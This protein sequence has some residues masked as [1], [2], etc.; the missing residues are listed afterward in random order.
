MPKKDTTL[1][2]FLNLTICSSNIYS[3]IMVCQ[4]RIEWLKGSFLS[5][6]SSQFV[7]EGYTWETMIQCDDNECSQNC[8]LWDVGEGDST[9]VV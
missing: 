2:Q 5:K 3:A 7:E 9:L 4:I 6:G 1:H 8:A